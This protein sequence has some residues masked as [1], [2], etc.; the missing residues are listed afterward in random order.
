MAIIRL[1]DAE[2]HPQDFVTPQTPF[3]VRVQNS[4]VITRVVVTTTKTRAVN[5][6][7]YEANDVISEKAANGTSW[8]F[9][10]MGRVSGGSGYI[11][12]ARAVTDDITGQ[13]QR[14]RLYLFNATPTSEL[15]DL[16]TNSQPLYA[17]LSKMIGTIDF[18]AL[19]NAQAGADSSET[20]RDD[21]RLAYTCDAADTALY[22]I[23]IT[24]DAFTPIAQQKFSVTLEAERSD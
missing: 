24:L 16:A 8:T 17:D 9:A 10:G 11:V 1:S 15:D 6:T 3:P 19:D 12:K 14:L 7:A 18:D 13:T 20:Q 5:T 2:G 22:G 4:S 21:L 23:L